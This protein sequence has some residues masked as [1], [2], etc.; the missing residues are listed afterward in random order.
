MRD[1]C[2]VGL[3]SSVIKKLNLNKN[4]LLRFYMTSYQKVFEISQATLQLYKKDLLYSDARKARCYG[5]V[6]LRSGT[7]QCRDSDELSE[8]GTMAACCC[9]VGMLLIYS[10]IFL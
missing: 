3:G 8:D 5:K 4:A 6:D 10:H 7:E 9:S 1:Y 2:Q